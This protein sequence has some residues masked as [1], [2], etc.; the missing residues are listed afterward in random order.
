MDNT[1]KNAIPEPVLDECTEK[2]QNCAKCG[3]GNTSRDLVFGHE[4][5]AAEAESGLCAA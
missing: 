3:H 1:M 2:L 5:P 4:C